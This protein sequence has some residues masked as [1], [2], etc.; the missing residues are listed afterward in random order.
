MAEK[1][2][3]RITAD[4]EINTTE[5]ATVLGVT[6]RRV[7]Q[8]AQDGTIAPVQRGRFLLG[9][10][11]QRYIAFFAKARDVSQQDRERLDAEVDIKKAKAIISGLE[12]K[13]LQG[14]MHRTEDVE[15]II[16]DLVYTIRGMLVAFPGRLAVDVH[17]AE[18]SAEASII[19][20]DEVY[21]VLEELANYKYDPAVFAKKVRERRNWD[22][23]NDENE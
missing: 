9:E 16:T 8:M 23:A 13:E 1:K 21:K 3:E 10:S 5:L 7:Q 6:A 15:S 22:G 14:K 19:I 17:N 18:S 20:R 11:V 4:T 2:V 12:A